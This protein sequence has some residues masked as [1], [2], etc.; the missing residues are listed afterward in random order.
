MPITLYNTDGR[1]IQPFVPI[2]PGEVGLY[3]CGLTVYNFA[4]IGN[5]RQY[6]SVDLLRRTL[7]YL[8]YAVRHVMNITDVG[9]LTGD[10]DEGEDKMIRSSRERGMSVWEIAEFYTKA[11]FADIERLN[12][13][14][15][16]VVCKATEHIPEMIGLI[17]RLEKRGYTYSAGGNVYFD[18]RRVPD[19]GRLA[20]LER[21][22]LLAGARVD[23]DSNK[24]DPRDFVLWFT[25]SKFGHQAMLWDSPWGKGYPGW[26]IECSAM[27]M[28]YLGE[29]FDIHCGGV[30]H[31]PVHHTNEIAQSE[32]AT[33]KH[34]V[35][36]WLHGEFLLGDG[37]AKMAK[38]EGGFVTLSSLVESG[39]DPL[40][41]RYLCLGTHY[42]SRLQFSASA[43]D[44]AR[45]ARRNL[46]ERVSRLREHGQAARLDALTPR[47]ISYREFFRQNLEADLGIPRALAT[48]WN[49]LKEPDLS[50]GE[51]LALLF[52]MD[53]VLGL[54]LDHEERPRVIDDE[55][56][57]LIREREA[58]RARR[59]FKKADEIRDTL[60]KRGI[61]LE[62]SPEGTK[63]SITE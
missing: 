27:S 7:E 40:D 33:G 38:S 52:D 10:G 14:M 47:G 8:G 31:I 35:N 54:D 45:A 6:V 30:D 4:H 11:F 20:L 60:R 58:E 44:G 39:Y 36:Y 22:D 63:W 50:E 62:D 55:S 49:L 46:V 25:S 59:N 48:V 12:I 61:V 26:H 28:K 57:G 3:A 37:G 2:V 1:Q 42:R 19:Y 32:A 21:Q 34:W 17:E 24:K 5:L 51:K 56:L 15:P 16:T 18:V 29:Q 43:I 9:H 13:T 23:V 41:F 53:R